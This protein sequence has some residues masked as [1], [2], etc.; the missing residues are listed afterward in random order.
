MTEAAIQ[1]DDLAELFRVLG[2]RQR[3]V[4]LQ[5]LM[6][7]ERAVGEIAEITG[8]G[9]SM[10]S[11]QLAQLRK[12]ALVAT[13]REG[14]QVFYALDRAGLSRVRDICDALMPGAAQQAVAGMRDGKLGAAMFARVAPFNSPD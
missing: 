5:S 2:N 3:L 12:A 7:G 9:M 6:D 8:M 4:V 13:R 1:I 14:K 10:V 11:Q